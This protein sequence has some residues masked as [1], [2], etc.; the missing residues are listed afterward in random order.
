M[1]A[2]VK[3]K[4]NKAFQTYVPPHPSLT[5]ADRGTGIL[6]RMELASFAAIGDPIWVE[7]GRDTF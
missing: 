6:N 1:Y 5:F 7:S 2:Q 4:R 3:R